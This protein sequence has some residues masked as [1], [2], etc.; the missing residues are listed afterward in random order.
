MRALF[1][2]SIEIIGIREQAF[3]TSLIWGERLTRWKAPSIALGLLLL[4]AIIS[5]QFIVNYFETQVEN[6]M[7]LHASEIA[8]GLINGMN[9]LMVTGKIKDP[10]N[11]KL[12]VRKMG[13]SK[14]VIEVRII[15]A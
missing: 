5:Q 3:M 7:K 1:N 6:G 14:E 4:L 11:R 10:E 9:M 15:R 13:D 2:R 8:D 12:M